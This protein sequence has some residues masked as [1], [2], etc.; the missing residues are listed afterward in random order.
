MWGPASDRTDGEDR[1]DE[2]QSYFAYYKLQIKQSSL[3]P[4]GLQQGHEQIH[5][6]IQILKEH[7]ELER[8]QLRAICETAMQGEANTHHIQTQ[9]IEHWLAL[10]AET[11]LCINCRLGSEALVFGQSTLSWEEDQSLVSLIESVFPEH[12]IRSE[13]PVI[14]IKQ[15]KLRARY[16]ENYA[17]VNIEWTSNLADHLWLDIRDTGKTLHI[18]ELVCYLEAS[19]GACKDAPLLLSS[20]ES[21][22]R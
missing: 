19:Y 5:P 17:D 12:R 7:P 1:V 13:D 21:L 6:F 8:R 14:N 18:F 22:R 2:L 3:V 20:S 4:N 15:N 10:A 16:L 11:L 9:D